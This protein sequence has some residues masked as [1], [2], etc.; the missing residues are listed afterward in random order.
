MAILRTSQFG[1]SRATATTRPRIV[2]ERMP[3][4]ATY[5][6]YRR[7]T[8]KARPQL[9]FELYGMSENRTSKPERYC[10]NPHPEAI[11]ARC[12]LVIVFWA[13]HQNSATT[14]TASAT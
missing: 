12:R 11:L 1:D 14:E 3:R 6:V 10:R 2:A 7:P 9:E 13:S 5:R 4:D 8:M